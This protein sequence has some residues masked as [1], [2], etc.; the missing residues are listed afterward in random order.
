MVHKF[1]LDWGS[2]P[3]KVFHPLP[4]VDHSPMPQAMMTGIQADVMKE[5]SKKGRP[6]CFH[7]TA[8][9][10]ETLLHFEGAS[11]SPS[12]DS[13]HRFALITA[14]CGPNSAVRKTSTQ[15]WLLCFAPGMQSAD[16][17]LFYEHQWCVRSG[18]G[19]CKAALCTDVP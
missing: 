8:H 7:K 16:L 15:M 9:V 18:T 17:D 2:V 12:V 4:H 1:A 13:W 3:E 6:G 14:D 19:I 5:N 11:P 10:L